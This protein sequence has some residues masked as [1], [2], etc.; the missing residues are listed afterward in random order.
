MMR[1]QI[2]SVLLALCMALALLPQSAWAAESKLPFTDVAEGSWYYE[3]V[4]YIYQHGIMDGASA[5]TFS[6]DTPVTRVV[7]VTALYRMEGSPSGSGGEFTDVVAGDAKAVAWASENKI[8]GGYGNGKFGP[9]DPITRQDMAAVLYR[10]AKYKNE[11]SGLVGNLERF[12]DAGQVRSYAVEPLTWATSMGLINGVGN[13]R[14]NPGGTTTRA[15][16][17]TLMMRLGKG[18]IRSTVPQD[19][20]ERAVWYGFVPYALTH[21]DPDGTVVTWKDYC[22]MISRLVAATDESLITQWESIARRALASGK[23]MLRDQGCVALYRAIELLG[24]TSYL[25][26]G[27][28]LSMS[29]NP[30]L[31]ELGEYSCDYREF[32][33]SEK[34]P[35]EEITAEDFSRRCYYDVAALN[36]HRRISA[37]SGMPYYD[38]NKQVSE[39][40]TLRDAACSVLRLYEGNDKP[41]SPAKMACLVWESALEE[42]LAGY[43]EAAEITRLRQD[44]LQSSTEIVKSDTYIPGKTYTGRAFYVSKTGNDANDGQSPQKAWATLERVRNEGLNPGDAIFLERGGLY[45]GVLNLWNPGGN[46]T[47]SAYGKGAKPIVTSAPENAA[48]AEKWALYAQGDN[49][50][51]IWKFYRDITDCGGIIFDD[52]EV[53]CKVLP[54]WSG[55]GWR[56]EDGTPFDVVTGLTENLDF[57]SDD[58]GRFHG[59]TDYYVNSQNPSDVKYGPLYLRCDEGNPGSLYDSIELCTMAI[60]P[61]HGSYQ[62]T[63]IS[64]VE[65]CTID[66]ICVKYYPHFGV[67]YNDGCVIQNC[68]FAWGGGCV[69]IVSNGRVID[70]RAG[71]ALCG[72]RA[73]NLL[74]QNNYFHD[75]FSATIIFESEYQE[76]PT[77]DV[78][79]RGNLCERTTGLNFAYGGGAWGPEAKEG[80]FKNFEIS[81]NIFSEAGTSW[82]S[83]QHFRMGNDGASLETF[84]RARQQHFF[85]NCRITDNSFYYPLQYFFIGSIAQDNTPAMS[86]NTYYFAKN[87]YGFALWGNFDKIFGLYEVVPPEKAEKFLREYWHDT[88]S[89]VVLAK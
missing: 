59:A 10:Y 35:L 3:A 26:N 38:P 32:A 55:T 45:R 65:G 39:P 80:T 14:I 2:L 7:V 37:V 76:T 81:G 9:D 79:F 61:A 63:V 69:Q 15:Q 87:T 18:N 89:K 36:C 78:T 1:K 66:N 29:P 24:Q 30:H 21:S 48:S 70:G 44:I 77:E 11:A 51:Q 84:I 52:S 43:T 68:E 42:E 71:D 54:V 64:I 23:K 49:G 58:G 60:S 46:V 25:D 28:F 12:A 8:V 86:G 41:G 4:Q 74:V 40:L 13:D 56:N 5:T 33:G 20:Y 17:A 72:G 34:W 31:L 62:G 6:P 53:G 19:E 50:E 82:G 85:E 83:R 27:D 73:K 67:T 88:T 47:L 57:F 16:A 22:Q 75:I